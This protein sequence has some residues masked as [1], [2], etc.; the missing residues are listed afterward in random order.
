MT[1]IV[2]ILTDLN[3][4]INHQICQPL[5]ESVLFVFYLLKISFGSVPGFAYESRDILFVS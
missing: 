1:Q 5:A 4:C 3:L 2:Q